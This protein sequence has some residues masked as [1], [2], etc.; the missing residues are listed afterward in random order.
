MYFLSLRKPSGKTASE[1]LGI[2]VDREGGDS[3]VGLGEGNGDFGF[4]DVIVR[5]ERVNVVYESP[6][7]NAYRI[8]IAN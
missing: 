5:E 7:P 6:N 8:G 4:T 3:R 2:S 1:G